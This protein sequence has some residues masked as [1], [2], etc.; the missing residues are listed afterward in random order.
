MDSIGK[1]IKYIIDSKHLTQG[2]FARELNLPRQIVSNYVNDLAK[3][4][5]DFLYKLYK[6]ININLNWLI[7]GEGGIYNQ[8]PNEALKDELRQEFEELL[9]AKG[10]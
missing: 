8:T 10:L 7:V 1:R 9:K 3:P 2:E 4:S 5:Y 6:E